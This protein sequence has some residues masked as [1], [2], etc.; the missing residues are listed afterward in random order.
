MMSAKPGKAGETEQAQI[1][2]WDLLVLTFGPS[3][4][5]LGR[6]TGH[7]VLRRKRGRY[8]PRTRD[9]KQDI[10]R[11]RHDVPCFNRYPVITRTSQFRTRSELVEGCG[12][13]IVIFALYLI[14]D[15]IAM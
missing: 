7:T 2:P 1:I 10:S 12:G 11:M 6:D 3:L 15:I 5:C 4:L 13:I 14:Y 8:E 9:S